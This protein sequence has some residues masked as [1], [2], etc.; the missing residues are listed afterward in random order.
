MQ[1]I[2]QFYQVYHDIDNGRNYI[3]D[4]YI[5][6]MGIFTLCFD[7]HFSDNESTYVCTGDTFPYIFQSL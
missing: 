1:A 4:Y 7:H 3:D 2:F 6:Y 5:V